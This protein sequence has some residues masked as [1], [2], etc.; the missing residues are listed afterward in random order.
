MPILQHMAD[1]DGKGLAGMGVGATIKLDNGDVC[2]L[3]LAQIGVRV[4]RRRSMFSSPVIYSE[5]DA[6]R[7]ARCGIAL[8]VLFPEIAFPGTTRNPVLRAYANAI[9]HC[10][11]AD[12]V[13][14]T[15]YEANARVSDEEINDFA[16]EFFSPP[17]P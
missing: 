16:A 10:A 6:T 14:R 2:V 8:T 12:E 9:W 5:K 15:L 3:S 4:A 1:A 7:A 11:D 13:T 17:P